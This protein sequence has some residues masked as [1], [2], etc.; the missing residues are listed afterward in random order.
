M[1]LFRFDKNVTHLLVTGPNKHQVQHIECESHE[2]SWG[3][4]RKEISRRIRNAAT[5]T[6]AV[7]V[8]DRSR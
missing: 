5:S 2:K 1:L 8:Q 7:Q 4:I 6:V 3:Y